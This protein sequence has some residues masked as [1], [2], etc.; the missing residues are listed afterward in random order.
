MCD[1]E[2]RCVASRRIGKATWERSA[3]IGQGRQPAAAVPPV[4]ATRPWR[5]VTPTERHFAALALAAPRPGLGEGRAS[6]GPQG[7][8]FFLML[9]ASIATLTTGRGDRRERL[10]RGARTYRSRLALHRFGLEQD[11]RVC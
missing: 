2:A 7:P 6:P 9:R 4:V 5:F 10:A 3:R 1:G 8:G 11:R